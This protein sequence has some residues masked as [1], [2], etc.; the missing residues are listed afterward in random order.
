MLRRMEGKRAPNFLLRQ[1]RQARRETQEQTAQTVGELLDHPVDPE[2]IGRLERGVVSWPNAGHRSAFRTHFGVA[3]DA[4]LGFYCRR[5][6]SSLREAD[7]VRRRAF[8]SALPLA[9]MPGTEPLAA[10]VSLANDEPT[11]MPR[12]VGLEQVEQVRAVVT[13]VDQLSHRFGGGVV[14]EMLGAQMRW[15]VDL[16]DAHVDRAASDELHSVI[17]DL[18]AYAGWS[19]HDVGADTAAQRYYQVALR[20]AEQADDWNLRAEA[21]SDMARI[22]QYGGDGETALT[23]S[24][25]AQVRADRLT[26]LRR[27]CLAAVEA[28]AHGQRGDA[29]ACLAAV[30]RAED[31]FAA[32]DPANET[33]GMVAFYSSAQLA[34]DSGHAL[35]PLALR[36][37]HVHTAA[38]RLRRAADS[39]PVGYA[40][41]RTLGLTRLASLTFAQGDPAEAVGVA[42]DA[43]DGTGSV[44]SHRVADNLIALRRVARRHRGV[45][46]VAPL[47]Q[48]ITRTLAAV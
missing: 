11:P 35:W 12:R 44:Q 20:C 10:L 1:A 15:A 8:L 46:G 42:T 24:Q 2:Y 48:R 29:N 34:G 22:A 38:D 45:P 5:S 13:Q 39:Y 17:G 3:S 37:Q 27:A 47:R 43:L 4:E 7:D 30:G 14:R 23:L 16:L 9:A 31:H 21:V 32:A 41:S 19:S 18:A 36:G 28:G 33:P 6:E 26:P 40:R 25:Q